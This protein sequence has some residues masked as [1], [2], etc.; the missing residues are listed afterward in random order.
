[1]ITEACR[2]DRFSSCNTFTRILYV[3]NSTLSTLCEGEKKNSEYYVIIFV[4]T[5]LQRSVGRR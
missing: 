4:R 3:S 5:P 1:M 2:S